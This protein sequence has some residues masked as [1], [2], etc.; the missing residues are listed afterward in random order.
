MKR[1]QMV[2]VL[3]TNAGILGADDSTGSVDFW[4]NGGVGQP[5]CYQQDTSKLSIEEPIC[6]HRR[7]WIYFAESVASLEPKFF[8]VK[9]ASYADFKKF[10]CSESLRMN[11]MGIDTRKQ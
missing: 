1:F 10:N 8:A 4:P 11:N 7:S 2:D 6:D 5:G 9:C 3:H